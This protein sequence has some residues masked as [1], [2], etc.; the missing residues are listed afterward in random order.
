MIGK[1]KEERKGKDRK[2]NKKR[3]EKRYG[4]MRE[5][6]EREY[7]KRIQKKNTEREYRKV[8]GETVLNRIESNRKRVYFDPIH[9][10]SRFFFF[11]SFIRYFSK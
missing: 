9:D 2:E 3:T 4:A 7:R 6:T 8:S 5:N 1:K 10:E 11:Y